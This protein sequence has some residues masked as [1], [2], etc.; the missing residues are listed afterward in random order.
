M[1]KHAT[2]IVCRFS[3]VSIELSLKMGTKISMNPKLENCIFK[4]M[5]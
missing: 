2:E 4:Q 5:S 3:V 1:V